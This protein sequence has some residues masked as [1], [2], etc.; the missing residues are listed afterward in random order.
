MNLAKRAG[1]SLME[2]QAAWLYPERHESARVVMFHRGVTDPAGDLFTMEAHLTRMEEAL[3]RPIATRIHWVRGPLLGQENFSIY[4]LAA[5]TPQ[6]DEEGSVYIAGVDFHEAGHAALS[7]LVAP[8]SDVPMVLWEG[9]AQCQSLG[10]FGPRPPRESEIHADYLALVG[11]DDPP[12][13]VA[14]L[15]SPAWYHQDSGPVYEVG[16]F[17]VRHLITRH[18]PEDFLKLCSSLRADRVD[19]V[20]REVYGQTPAEIEAEMRREAA[21]APKPGAP[22]VPRPPAAKP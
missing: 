4:G 5:G 22:N 17:L 21:A 2:A 11:S 16:P 18:G 20:F 12:P 8:R 10:H 9:W 3:G 14:D 15:F 13:P 7:Q 19:A 6:P 1:A